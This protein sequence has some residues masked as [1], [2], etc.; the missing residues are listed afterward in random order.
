[1]VL[2]TH[3]LSLKMRSARSFVPVVI[4]FLAY[5]SGYSQV[6][7]N[8]S[9]GLAPT[10][11]SLADAISALN[12][13]VISAPIIIDVNA[14]QT[15]PASG[16]IITAQGTAANTITLRGNNNTVVASNAHLPGNF[17]DAIFRLEGA[18]YLTLEQFVM[19]ENPSAT[20]ASDATNTV[21]EWG[22]ALLASSLT[23]GSQNNIIRN[24]TI[25][26]RVSAVDR[27]TFGIYSNVRHSTASVLGGGDP[28]VFSGTN[29]NNKIHSNAINN[30]NFGISF[31]G[32]GVSG[33]ADTGNE[34]GGTLA[35]TGNTITE[36]GKVKS[37]V[38]YASHTDTNFGIQAINQVNETISN[39][40]LVSNDITS[41][42][43]I[44]GA[45]G[46]LKYY[47][48]D[49]IG[50]TVSTISNNMIT[51]TYTA[52]TSDVIGI[53]NSSAVAGGAGQ[54]LNITDNKIIKCR[55]TATTTL[56]ILKGI[57]NLANVGTL[58]IT[59]NLIRGCTSAQ[60]GGTFTA[61]ENA[62]IVVNNININYNLLGN[63]EGTAILYTGTSAPNCQLIYNS[64]GGSACS[65]SISGN[66]FYGISYANTVASSVIFIRTIAQ[67]IPSVTISNNLFNNIALNTSSTVFFFQRAANSPANSSYTISGNQIVGSF[68]KSGTAGDIYFFDTGSGFATGTGSVTNITNNNF[69]NITSFGTSRLVGIAYN[70]GQTLS[71]VG[72][73]FHNWNLGGVSNNGNV[74]IRVND[75]LNI[76]ISN[77]TMSDIVTPFAF[78]G[79]YTSYTGN[80]AIYDNNHML[81]ISAGTNLS[82]EIYEAS[83]TT[84]AI[85]NS[86]IHNLISNTGVVTGI[87]VSLNNGSTLSTIRNIKVSGLASNGLASTVS[88]FKFG[89]SSTNIGSLTIT[90]NYIGDLNAPISAVDNAIKAIEFS[91]S[92]NAMD[93]VLYY[94][95]IFINAS[96]SGTNF[97]ASV[98]SSVSSPGF[99]RLDLRNNIF[100]NHS[101]PN[102]TGVSAVLRNTS[103]TAANYKA[104]NNHNLFSIGTP[105][106]QRYIYYS[107]A[108]INDPAFLAFQARVYPRENRS[109]NEFP[110][111][112]SVDGASADFLHIDPTTS[113]PIENGGTQI[114]GYT[115]DFDNVIRAGNPGYTGIGSLP[116]IGADEGD[117]IQ[118][119][120]LGPEIQYTPLGHT[121]S[122][123]N[124]NLGDV[125]IND[126]NGVNVMAGLKP[127]LYFKK[128]AQANTF[129]DNTSATDGWKYVE[130][131]GVTSPFDFDIDYALLNG[132]TPILG[133]TMQYFV[134]AQDNYMPPSVTINSGVPTLIPG[135][136]ALD[137]SHFPITNAINSYAIKVGFGGDMTVCLSG[138]DYPSLTNAGGIFQAI[139]EGIVTDSLTIRISGDL[140][141]ELGTHALNAFT[142]NEQILIRPFG[143]VHRII[144]GTATTGKPLIGLNGADNVIIDGISAGGDTLT[145]ANF[146]TSTSSGTSTIRF[147]NG[148]S[149][150]RIKRCRVLGSSRVFVG[151]E[152]AVILFNNI[153]VGNNSNLIEDCDVGP[154][155]ATLPIMLITSTGSSAHADNVINACRLYDFFASSE[156]SAGIY[157]ETSGGTGWTL[158]NNR[159][160]QTA[161]RTF[162]SSFASHYAISSYGAKGVVI[163]NN[164][165][166]F[167]SSAGTGLYSMVGLG[168]TKWIV[169]DINSGTVASPTEI[170]G[171]II[172]NLSYTGAMS[173]T[174]SSTTF[175]AIKTSG[176][177]LNIGT[178][179]GNIIGDT[180][181]NARITYSSS[182]ASS[183]DINGIFVSGST[184]NVNIRNNKIGGIEA[185]LGGTGGT[186]IF[187]VQAADNAL[188]DCRFNTIGG[189]VDHSIQS[190]ASNS[191][192]VRGIVHNANTSAIISGNI[193][194]NL[195]SNCSSSGISNLIGI[196]ITSTALQ[197]VS[198][199]QIYKLKG[200]NTTT[201]VYHIGIR[202]STST[203]SG[204]VSIIDGNTIHSIESA[205]FS[206]DIMGLWIVN[207]INTCTNNMIRL[208]L[209]ADGSALT[210]PCS[211]SGIN[212]NAG[213][214]KLFHNSI[215]VGGT[216][217][218]NSMQTTA[219]FRRNNT[220][221]FE[222]R[223]NIFS[224]GRQNASSGGKHYNV[225]LAA[226]TGITNNL[227][228]NV[229]YNTG[230]DG[231]LFG[232]Y[233][234][235]E[236][237]T[238]QAWIALMQSNSII[239]D[240]SSYSRIP[241]FVSP[242][243]NSATGDL[244]IQPG[245]SSGVESRGNPMTG[246]V[247]DIDGQVRSVTPDIGADEGTFAS[248]N[249][250][251]AR[252]DGTISM[253]NRPL[254]NVSITS[255]NGVN[256]SPGTRPRVY[257][258]KTTDSNDATGWKH[259][260]TTSVGS[261][262]SF[263]IDYTLLNSGMVSPL[264][265][266]QYF[267]VAQDLA[268][269]PS[270]VLE[271][272]L[273]TALPASVQ[274]GAPEFP[275]LDNINSY[276][277]K[278]SIS[279]TKT[280]CASGCDYT[281]LTNNGGIFSDINSVVV[282][283]DLT[284]EIRDNL[285]AETG[286]HPLNGYTPGYAITIR[287]AGGVTRVVS[288]AI[289]A[290][291]PLID[292]NG[293]DSVLV[294]GRNTGG[295]SLFITNT[296]TSSTTGTSTIQ[297][298]NDSRSCTIRNC[299]I[300]GSSTSTGSGTVYITASGTITG[301]DN[302]KLVKNTIGGAGSNTPVNAIY[303]IGPGFQNNN[304]VIDSNYIK[305]YFLAN[306]ACAG[307]NILSNCPNV[308]IR[309]NHFFQTVPRIKTGGTYHA[310]I[311]VA[312]PAIITDNII[313]G[314]D[315][316]HG[317]TYTFTGVTNSKVYPIYILTTG[318]ALSTITGN[319][320]KNISIA[321]AMN[322]SSD[323]NTPFTAIYV[324]TGIT[325]ISGN[326]IG[327]T[328]TTSNITYTTTSGS[329]SHVMGICNYAGGNLT[330]NH[331]SMGGI[332]LIEGGAGAINFTGIR[333]VVSV[334]QTFTGKHNTIGGN[335]PSSIQNNTLLTSRNIVGMDVLAGFSVID[336]NTIRNLKSAGFYGFFISGSGHNIRHNEIYGL[337]T[338]LAQ[339]SPS[340]GIYLNA[341]GTVEGNKIHS[342]IAG[343]SSASLMGILVQGGVV[344]LIN[345]M[346]RLGL[347]PDGTSN[348]VSNAI[349]GISAAPGT[350]TNL[351]FNSIFIGGT[352]TGTSATNTYCAQIDNSIKNIRNNIFFNAR[353]N[354][355]TGGKH[356]SLRMAN[357]TGM[358]VD[359]N[360]YHVTGT[361]GV[362]ANI[363]SA[364]KSSI[365]TLRSA[366]FQDANSSVGDPK[367]INPS[368]TAALFDLHIDT[369]VETP[370]EGNG[371]AVSGY[372]LDYDSQTRATFSPVDIG[373]DAGTFIGKDLILPVITYTDLSADYVKTS[374][375]LGNV[376]ISDNAS[377]IDTASG[378]RPRLYFKKSTDP[379]TD[380][381]W[382][383]VEANGTSSPFDFTINYSLLTAGS[384]AVG[385]VIQ[386]FV[387]AA[388][389]ATTPNVGKNAAVFSA[390]PTS[391]ALMSA[392]F[393]ING[394][395]KSFTIIDTLVG[396][397]TVCASGCD[398]TSLT[399]NDAGGA[400]KAINDRILTADVLLQIT[401][402]LTAESGA[403]S[404]N[405]FAAPYTVTIKPDG[406]PRLVSYSGAG[407][408]IVLNGADRV[409]IDGSL[410][411]TANTLCPVMQASRDLTFK[412]TSASASVINLR[413]Q[414]TNPATNNVIK[415]CNIEG[416]AASTTT[417]GIAS[418]DQAVNISSLGKD[419]DN[420]SFVNNMITRVQ[421][422]IYSQGESRSNK[423]QG[424]I[425]QL[426]TIDLTSSGNTA[427]AGVYLGF[428]NNAQVSGNTIKNISN[429][430]RSVAGIALGLLPSLN[431]TVFNGND[432][433]NCQISLNTIRDISRIGDGS[434][435]G[436]SMAAVIS[437]ASSTNELSNNMLF[438]VNSTTAT[439]MDYIAG[440]LVGGGG[441][442]T[443]KVLYNTVKL[444]GVSSFSA[445]GYAMAIGSGNPGIEMKNNIFVNEM[446]STLG[447]NYALGLAY[448][449][450]FSNLN[451]DRN[452]FF[453]TA[454][455]LAITG[456]LNNSPSGNLTNLAAYQALTGK[457]MNSKNALPEFVSSTDLHL[458]TAAVNLLNLDGKGMPVSTTIDIDCDTRSASN[459]DIGADEIA[460]CNYPTIASLAADVNP[461]PCSGNT[462]NLT[463]SGM[464][465][466]GTDWTWYKGSCEG[467]VEGTGPTIS[468]TPSATT[469]YYVRGEGGCVTGNSCEDITIMITGSI[470]TNTSDAGA[471]SLR[472]AIT[473]AGDGD[474]LVFDPGVL[475]AGDTLLISSA[476]LDI[477]K[478]ITIDQEAS[479]IVKIKTT[480]T[481]SIF[482][483]NA[484]GT[485]N[486]RN[487]QL[488]MN[489]TSPT[490]QGRAV[491]NEGSLYLSDVSVYEKQANLMGAG[492]T[493]H[494]LPGSL[495]QIV[496]GCQIIVQ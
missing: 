94:N 415:N 206:Q 424:T 490:T 378:L 393:P 184:A 172:S 329:G 49:P 438:N 47:T 151:G 468:V 390:T 492:T 351:Y 143:G 146:S 147:I 59:G 454:S 337:Q 210:V 368:G 97:G 112:L 241:F 37:S 333:S 63:E 213:T 279:G 218:L 222:V 416:N 372:N 72:N 457:D 302:I 64:N 46:I 148:A 40:T 140:V 400:F 420:N 312:S 360:V 183:S 381:E 224:N 285:L 346:I 470:V 317:G 150:N 405:A 203:T 479:A 227:N 106:A 304:L 121:A 199:N 80:T 382:K 297:F 339:F 292:F 33:N 95:T 182:S 51:L 235:T 196:D 352:V 75:A 275:I 475:N 303:A 10:Y 119:D 253:A 495:I 385:D 167:G 480:G 429:N 310:A 361:N 349:I 399:N 149:G 321:G 484:S 130:A 464:L 73:T 284:I 320:I 39:N 383:Y 69:S 211:I 240:Q 54:T 29:S 252:L 441:V 126:I 376:L 34:L 81:N 396:T 71:I 413:S 20:N 370:V 306:G 447:K 232:I 186:R 311:R 24:N 153:A 165:I 9:S 171:N 259:V 41:S 293:A 205:T 375:P 269:T 48:A 31:T 86:V 281:S 131:N 32:S 89:S 248:L 364:D 469:T 145:I 430:T 135:T 467:T 16:Y 58:N 330:A 422:G 274:L 460:G 44:A 161:T 412:N 335:V 444:S 230:G 354:A 159:I 66:Q 166:G 463:V 229:Y 478:S 286:T 139:N 255:L 193:I 451:S 11:P 247:L 471:G 132:G 225:Q 158:T 440:I 280:I 262:F 219:A 91:N 50:T 266:I 1:V 221:A 120:I 406:A 261:P 164:I 7:T 379:N 350:E 127:R 485:L 397:K 348:D 458:T 305:D 407:S 27:N 456:G 234:S 493:I 212:E 404:L 488:F 283:G 98:L 197:T 55:M 70:M 323:F 136:V 342:L 67:S 113:T 128:K 116:D 53:F 155:S 324:S 483:I 418:T 103:L 251:Y 267:V 419:N 78:I 217:V 28:T 443:T 160:F 477:S 134:V 410:S 90:N 104:N 177:V 437:G 442:G 117:F 332:T 482:D 289:A 125:Y 3:Q 263:T 363:V 175:A 14:D 340:Y 242:D 187:G 391:V 402:D 486:L 294:D 18:D 88:G 17:M 110:D 83:H 209:N 84:L 77:N 181:L 287:P 408:L 25:S 411:T 191:S 220:A 450:S 57:S 322:G 258:K 431:M 417:F 439:T 157:L 244:H 195:T 327:D 465:N 19:M 316:M 15:A 308:L 472:E 156:S 291:K 428:E 56:N 296:S 278:R 344:Q 358:V 233:A 336:S 398:F 435:F 42:A 246:V 76:T 85:S 433:S 190:L 237:A 188:M 314:A 491:F 334:S 170:Q 455:P 215:Y 494:N 22:V 173:G 107:T 347:N 61:I 68:S 169:L 371:V 189:L 82:G 386:Y 403:V 23:N 270:V 111:F 249:I 481:H 200:I 328:T 387:V 163:N 133:D 216:G 325:T 446:T 202:L 318:T 142:E 245:N 315:P 362:L 45:R 309:N 62:G 299:I 395:I 453:T 122:L 109:V 138:C 326:L 369:A 8:G 367:F 179:T 268:M 87:S 298:R 198:R 108:I 43:T 124:R 36:F 341:S 496:A 343:S 79:I 355:T 26:L 228:H 204:M 265:T 13:A 423:N 30:V 257:F 388:D 115:L 174:G 92:S 250:T 389:T 425:I 74:G 461:I 380:A 353:S 254:S 449:G 238:F 152:G 357:I 276:A 4:L 231:N 207:G 421:Y 474:T 448:N 264:D 236:V 288:G 101:T 114:A 272:G 105:A 271:V 260:E 118:A 277:I 239:A 359:H 384:V 356:Y 102:G 452:N 35:A 300:S 394:T 427:V 301:N 426:N 137:A 123:S 192:F 60:T 226:S 185:A 373:A 466:D 194:R 256:T 5:I 176:G 307:I 476:A 223:N 282:S 462:T 489:S 162:S 100:V 345:N 180:L 2:Q 295:D 38:L 21:T 459:P 52:S 436:I 392:Q 313:G 365:E 65:L 154:A 208:G 414:S 12:A 6:A 366:T 473:C 434:A 432:V 319:T 409:I 99:Y 178:V 243:G 129:N 290:G 201:I 487:V 214:L 168:S 273:P 445:P 331:N 338:N 144:S 374:R 93:Y 377:G 401:S 141:G 96:S